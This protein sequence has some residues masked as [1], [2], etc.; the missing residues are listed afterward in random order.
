MAKFSLSSSICCMCF[1]L[2]CLGPDYHS[3]RC[4]AKLA[5]HL[6][7]RMDLLLELLRWYCVNACLASHDSQS[8]LLVGNCTEHP[9]VR[10]YSMESSSHPLV[11]MSVD[12]M[13]RIPKKCV[14]C[15]RVRKQRVILR[16]KIGTRYMFCVETRSDFEAK[17]FVEILTAVSKRS[18]QQWHDL[19]V[20]T[21]VR[22][23]CTYIHISGR[24]YASY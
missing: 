13:G 22:C 8:H 17:E 10:K 23:F 6:S 1:V 5:A 3:L 9:L 15:L 2:D 21:I 11:R 12:C 24:K 4:S 18:I 7:D 14:M 16:Y 20:L 19:I